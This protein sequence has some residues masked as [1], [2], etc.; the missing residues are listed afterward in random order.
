MAFAALITRTMGEFIFSTWPLLWGQIGVEVTCF[1]PRSANFDTN[2]LPLNGGPLSER[3]CSGYPNNVNTLSKAFTTTSV[4]NENRV[5][6][7]GYF[8]YSSVMTSRYT[9]P[10]KG[11]Q[12]STLTFCHGDSGRG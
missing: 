11:P 12:K 6:T 8:E 9:F 4:A 3:T 5:M 2:S 1:T 7:M 10:S